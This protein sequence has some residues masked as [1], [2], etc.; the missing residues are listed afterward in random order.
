MFNNI[1]TV[2][3]EEGKTYISSIEFD[4]DEPLESFYGRIKGYEGK[5]FKKLVESGKIDYNPHACGACCGGGLPWIRFNRPI[6]LNRFILMF[7]SVKKKDLEELVNFDL[8]QISDENKK[9][10]VY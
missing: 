2:Q 9:K 6:S 8:G 1:E 10:Y 7:G 4:V 5:S 3:D